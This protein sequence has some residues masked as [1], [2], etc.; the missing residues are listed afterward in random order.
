MFTSPNL[1]LPYIVSAQAQKHVTHNEALRILDSVVQIGVR[2]RSNGGPPTTFE[3]GDRYIVA[4]ESDGAWLG[5]ETKIASFQDGAWS[6][7]QPQ[8]GW[9]AWVFDE[10]SLTVFDGDSWITMSGTHGSETTLSSNIVKWTDFDDQTKVQVQWELANQSAFLG[11]LDDRSGYTLHFLANDT[12][13]IKQINAASD[14]FLSLPYFDSVDRLI[15]SG[16]QRN[17]VGYV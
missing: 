1:S 16:R 6:F 10:D 3:E 14:A 15:I 8:T 5:Q 9:L 4:D 13:P 11:N 12:V 7:H 17:N 2:S